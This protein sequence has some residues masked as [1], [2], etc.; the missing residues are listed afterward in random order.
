M[1]DS[2]QPEKWPLHGGGGG[3]SERNSP[4]IGADDG[5][6]D[7]GSSSGET[8]AVRTPLPLQRP[9]SGGNLLL[10]AAMHA[11]A[12]G[13]LPASFSDMNND[14][15]SPPP[16][17]LLPRPPPLHAPASRPHHGGGGGVSEI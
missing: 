16:H 7:E 15:A 4:A 6:N 2:P 3:V 12:V 9:E 10:T 5:N 17:P 11:A 14:M 13:D 1:I 8:T